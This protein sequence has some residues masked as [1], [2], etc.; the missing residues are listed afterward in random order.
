MQSPGRVRGGYGVVHTIVVLLFAF[1]SGAAAAAPNKLPTVTLTAPSNG[2]TFAAP[3]TINL[4]ASASDS[5]GSIAKVEFYQG[6]NLIG[7]RTTAPYTMTWNGVAGGSY[8]LTAQATDNRGGVK[9]S[10]S[11]SITVTGPR[12]VISTPA[13]GATIYDGAVVVSGS[14]VGD[15]N[16]AVLVDNGNTTRVATLDGNA[17]TTTIPLYVGTNTLRVVASRRD[18]TSD[19]AT[20]VVT[21]SG[22]PLLAFTAPATTVFE[23]PANITLAIDAMSPASTISKV[24]FYRNGALLGTATSP[25]YQQ[26][27][28]NVPAGSYTVSATATDALGVTGSTSLAIAVSGLNVPPAVSLTSPANGTAFLAPASIAMAAN[29]TDSDGTVTLVEFLQNGVV[30]GT[31]N[32]VPY[33]LTWSNVAAGSY[34]LAARATDNRSGVTTSTPVN[35]IVTPPNYPPTVALTSPMG[36]AAYLA[37]ATIALAATAS[38]NDGS[39]AKVDFFAGATLIGTA[40]A[41]PY[42]VNWSG[43]PAGTYALTARATDN[44]GASTTSSAVTVTVNANQPPT[45]SLVAPVSGTTYQAPAT[46]GLTA[47][48]S[49]PDGAV[50]KVDFY[51]G[52]TLIGT[53]TSAPYTV[54]WTGVAAGTY[55]LTAKAT[56]NVGAVATSA[57]VTVSVSAPAL[58]ISSPADGATI[59][60]DTVTVSGALQAPAN[61]GV[62]VNG[63]V[64]A[65]DATGHFHATGVP[66]LVGANT[67][68]VTLTTLAGMTTTQ[69]LTVTSTGPGAVRITASP[70]QGMAPLE[71]VYQVSPGVATTIARVEVDI[72][73]NGSFDQVLTAEP[74][75]ASVTYSG[76]GTVSPVIRVTDAQ[77]VVRTEAIPIVLVDPAELDQNLRAVWSAMSTAL[78]AGDKSTAMR[79][80]DVSAQQ[81]YG[82][83]FDALLPNMPQIVGTFSALQSVTLSGGLGE[84]AV[85]RTINGEN[86]LFLIY[87]GRNGDG[88]WRLGSM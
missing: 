78:A 4:S 35:V 86:R 81:K 57:P 79:Y 45:A 16:T 85:N 12:V 84:Y 29:A 49:D 40:T 68:N 20:V 62:T 28:N 34:S 65:I 30:V 26:A 58:E 61:S 23:A 15:S 75:S 5:D 8:S 3:A 2:A 66:L 47:A 32:V 54:A 7:T 24:D 83:V 76:S 11:V 33:A 73:G 22:N 17:Y 10:A 36:G 27:W 44:L 67:I 21:G 56:D 80:L 48:A 64:A 53:A 25:P 74:W 63:V 69:A 71:V 31:T 14:F 88:V 42:T 41:A 87:F 19:Q 38:D 70:T 18:K 37:P 39:I 43:V 55:A 6:M 9:T 52:A 72:E 46:I 50:A 51:A 13:S 1:G 77:G 82:P 59:E 60:G